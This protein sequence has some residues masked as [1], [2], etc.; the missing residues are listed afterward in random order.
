MHSLLFPLTA[1]PPKKKKAQTPQ[2]PKR[3]Q[4]FLEKLVTKNLMQGACSGCALVFG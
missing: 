2:T 3:V 4:L 1:H